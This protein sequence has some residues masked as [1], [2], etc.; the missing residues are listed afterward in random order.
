M[1]LS[2][3]F[4]DSASDIGRHDLVFAGLVNRNDSWEQ[5]NAA[6]R[7]AL[8]KPPS[9]EHLKMV[10][11]N[12]LRGQFAGWSRDSRDKKLENLAEVLDRFRPLWTFDIS[13]SRAEYERHVSPAAP[14]GLSTP[15]FAITFGAVSVV[16]RYLASQGVKTP[17]RFMFDE[18]KGVDKDGA[19][20]FDYMLENLDSASR[21]LIQL[22]IGYGDDR[23]ALPLQVADMLA[24][25]IRWQREGNEDPTIVR[26]AEY[27]RSEAHIEMQLPVEMLLSWGTAFSQVLPI[28]KTLK[29]KGEWQRL[30]TATEKSKRDGFKPPHGDDPEETLSNIRAAWDKFR[31]NT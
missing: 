21:E 1:H 11:A 28:L 26:R 16:A 19:L 30:R 4:D 27:I 29:S 2:A 20:F 12:G 18:Q 8:A 14:R 6:W 25:H 17:L 3:Y 5:F 23:L 7:A 31:R 15:Y 9:I 22:P 24:W 13:V 10:E